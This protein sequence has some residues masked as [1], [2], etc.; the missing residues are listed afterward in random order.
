[1]TRVARRARESVVVVYVAVQTL[2]RRNCVR[3]GQRETGGG[4]VKCRVQPRSRIVALLAALRKIRCHMVRIGGSLIVLQVTAHAGGG[5]EAV[6]V[7]DMAIGALTWRHGVHAG[8]REFRCIV[9]KRC[10][11]PQSG[12]VALLAGLCETCRY[13]VRICGPLVILQVA[14]HAGRT[15]QVEVVVDVTVGTLPRRDRMSGGEWET[16]RAV[17]EV[18]M[19]PRICAVAERA[20]GGE[21]ARSVVGIAG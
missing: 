8:Q 6:I 15:G 20:V 16:C 9:V 4:M 2:T 17:I 3:S 11:C 18:R 21:A 13:V 7:S 1:M 10:V 19:E 12:V 5:G 14:A